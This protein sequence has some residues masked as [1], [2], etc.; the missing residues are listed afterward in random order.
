MKAKSC[1]TLIPLAGLLAGCVS[2]GTY[3]SLQQQNTALQKQ[4]DDQQ[5]QLDEIHR[6]AKGRRRTWARPSSRTTP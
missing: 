1:L 6:E 3:K 4:A 5:A 2:L